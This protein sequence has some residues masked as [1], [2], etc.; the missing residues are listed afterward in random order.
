MTREIQVLEVKR[1]PRLLGPQA[2]RG[3]LEWMVREDPQ[4]TLL[5]ATQDPQERG[6]FLDHQGQKDSEEILDVQGLQV[7]E[8]PGLCGPRSRLGSGTGLWRV[9]RLS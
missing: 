5:L 7:G 4:E 2:L 9:F 6:V 1:G 3:H 8:L